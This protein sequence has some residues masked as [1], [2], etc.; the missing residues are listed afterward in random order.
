MR[1]WALHDVIRFLRTVGDGYLYMEGEGDRRL[2]L[3]YFYFCLRRPLLDAGPLL[4]M[5]V[6]DLALS[7][8]LSELYYGAGC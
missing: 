3:I 7:S 5:I 4:S 6:V 2:C 1:L 8:E